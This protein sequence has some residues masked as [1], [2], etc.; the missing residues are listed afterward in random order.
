MAPY[1]FLIV[2]VIVALWLGQPRS[3][4]WG[5]AKWVVAFLGLVLLVP[6]LSSGSWHSRFDNPPLFTTSAYR[7]VIRPGSIVLPLPFAQWGES[8]LWQAETGFSFRMAD[9]YVGAL[10]PSG[11]AH[12]LGVLSSPQIQPKPSA[13]AAFLAARHVSTVIVGAHDPGTWPRVLAVLGLH[14]KAIDGTLVYSLPSSDAVPT[15]P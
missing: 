2:A 3:G 12:D 15:P 10:L 5:A 7:S 13:F 4:R 14:P 6:N 8:M 9:G 11:Y 1:M